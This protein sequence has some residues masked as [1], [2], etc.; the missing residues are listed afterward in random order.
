MTPDEL[1]GPGVHGQSPASWT[2]PC[3]DEVGAL[4]TAHCR[5][6]SYVPEQQLTVFAPFQ[7]PRATR[8]DRPTAGDRHPAA[9]RLQLADGDEHA[10]RRERSSSSR[11]A[12]TATTSRCSRN[13]RATRS[14]RSAASAVTS[15]GSSR[16]NSAVSS[17]ADRHSTPRYK[18]ARF[19]ALLQHLQHPG[20]L[21][22]RYDRL[23][24]RSRAGERRHRAG[25]AARCSTR[26]ST[27]A[28]R[29]SC[30]SFATRSAAPTPRS[31]ATRPAPTTS[32]RLP[33]HAR[34]GHGAGR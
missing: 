17:G 7:D 20:H 16:N 11:S 9:Q 14:P 26:S 19:I 3:A 18:N 25:R 23:P 4:R 1:G 30:S 8:C 29:V 21:H 31:T 28:R 33:D 13:G 5:L 22:G 32:S 6:L 12:T 34:R 24:A 2:S 15:S 27:S 10:L